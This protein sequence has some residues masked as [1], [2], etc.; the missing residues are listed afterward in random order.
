MFVF[1]GPKPCVLNTVFTDVGTLK[2]TEEGIGSF[3][4]GAKI[5]ELSPEGLFISFCFSHFIYF[6]LFANQL[7]ST[8]KFWEGMTSIKI[9]KS[10]KK[11]GSLRS[12]KQ[13]P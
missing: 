13:N 4:L 9:P 10:K 2:C 8:Q 12:P 6:P 3:A 5:F 7:V 1:S 11:S